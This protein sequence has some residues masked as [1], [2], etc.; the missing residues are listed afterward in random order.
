MIRLENLT[1]TFGN[2]ILLDHVT[3]HFPTSEKIALIG[4]NGAGK[5]TLLNI[6]C[7]LETQDQG[8]IIAPRNLSIGYLPQ[9]PNPH[10]KKTVL[11]ECQSGHKELMM[12][13]EEMEKSLQLLEE[14]PNEI[15]CLNYNHAEQIFQQ[16]DGYQWHAK[17]QSILIGLG[18]NQEQ[19]EKSPIELSGGWR[20]RLE[21]AK[22]FLSPHNFL[23]LDEPTNHL[24]LPS[25]V[26]VENYLQNYEGT[27]LFVSHDRELLNSLA[28]VTAHIQNGQLNFYQGNY[29]DFLI[30]KSQNALEAAASFEKMEKKKKQLEVFVQRFGS[31][32]SK[33]SQ[34]QSKQ[35]QIDR[36]ARQQEGIQL[37][38]K[39]LQISLKLPQPP[40]S[41]RLPI[42]ITDLSIGYTVPLA[43]KVHLAM[44]KG[45]KIGII[46]SN[47]IGKSTFLKTIVD[48]IPP[49]SGQIKI[50]DRTKIAYFSQDQLDTLDMERS[51]LDNVLTK[52]N[53][54]QAEARNLLGSLLFQSDD[55]FKPV[56]VLSG[57]EKSRVGLA[58]VLA[59]SANLLI[60]DEPTN[61]LDMKSVLCLADALKKY[62]GSILFV[63]HDRTF[64]DEIATHIFAV[65]G[66]KKSAML[67]EGGLEDYKKLASIAGFPNI[68]DHDDKKA[69]SFTEKKE[70]KKEMLVSKK[71]Q[72]K[73]KELEKIEKSIR[74]KT[75]EKNLLEQKKEQI[76]ASNNYA[77]LVKI[78]TTY[79]KLIKDI[80]DLEFEWLK[81]S[82]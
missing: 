81:L 2:K 67:F 14:E 17:A 39:D 44:E 68:L 12:L 61:H 58:V 16:K 54:A 28:S 43:T 65:S 55:V 31:K 19:L 3:C 60:L 50:A 70:D 74:I 62:T 64:I 30:A 27:L 7:Q 6:L 34:A 51:V 46:G 11:K 18:F 72:S 37:E 79:Q 69:S 77:E 36:L 66:E 48:I 45:Q 8:Q 78:E 26:W 41:D 40:P 52:T 23:I 80:E 10:P 82:E 1:K 49:L 22:L 57:G 53:L 42:S 71:S 35:K 73:Q 56:K 20:M 24:D 47:G 13:E 59:L 63:S 21:L 9:E 4:D 38:K 76:S 33:A 75:E 5:T 15:N 32:A 25:L 29:D